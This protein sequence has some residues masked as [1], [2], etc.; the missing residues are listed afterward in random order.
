[1][2]RFSAVHQRVFRIR[3]AFEAYVR[4]FR[5]FLM[6]NSLLTTTPLA[7]SLSFTLHDFLPPDD[8]LNNFVVYA[9]SESSRQ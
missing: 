3:D 4:L 1:M 8:V 2:C 7:I 9:I 6:K 5:I